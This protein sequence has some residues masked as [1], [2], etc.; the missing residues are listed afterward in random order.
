MIFSILIYR[1][2]RIL[3]FE[4]FGCGAVDDHSL[5]SL[6]PKVSNESRE[7]NRFLIG[8]LSAVGGIVSMLSPGD[9]ANKFE[10]LTTPEYRL[11]YFETVTGYK[12]VV[13]SEPNHTISR[14]EVRAE[15]EKLYNVLFVPL[16]IRNP[17][18]DPCATSGS[19]TD[20]KCN[21]FIEELRNHFQ[22]FNKQLSG[23]GTPPS[24]PLASAPKLLSISPQSSLI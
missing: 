20:S 4:D 2:T 21:V 23:S 19:L 12:F 6:S 22:V 24:N 17:L 15:F 5:L 14:F 18:F 3:H 8:M 7:S 10:F 9:E 16:V 11:D 1:N 13:M